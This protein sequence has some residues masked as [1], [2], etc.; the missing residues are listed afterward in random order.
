MCIE[1]ARRKVPVFRSHADSLAVFHACNVA[2][3][4]NALG[5]AAAVGLIVCAPLLRDGKRRVEVEPELLGFGLD[6]REHL[7]GGHGRLAE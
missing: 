1:F 6:E 3:G 2:C 5:S 4:G 7:R